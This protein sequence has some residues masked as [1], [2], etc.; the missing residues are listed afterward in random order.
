MLYFSLGTHGKH[1][2]LIEFCITSKPLQL[3][4]LTLTL[5][6]TS[7][8][9]AVA[10]LFE[11]KQLFRHSQG[12]TQQSQTR[13]KAVRDHK[14]GCFLRAEDL[15]TMGDPSTGHALTHRVQPPRQAAH[16]I[17]SPSQSKQSQVQGPAGHSRQEQREVKLEAGLENQAATQLQIL[18]QEPESKP[19]LETNYNVHPSVPSRDTLPVLHG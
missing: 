1:Q 12:I 19:R 15:G 16:P 14:D 5:K 3:T 17:S 8:L 11:R 6:P 13:Q 7:P 9:L 18:P 10:P 4:T 2:H